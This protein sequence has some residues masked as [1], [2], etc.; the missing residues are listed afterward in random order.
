MRTISMVFVII[1]TI[2]KVDAKI[3]V[4]SAKSKLKMMNISRITTQ[5]NSTF[6][7]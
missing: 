7:L 2:D 4:K 5:T 3:D 6:D 1:A